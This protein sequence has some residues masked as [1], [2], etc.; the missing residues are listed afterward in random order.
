MRRCLPAAGVLFQD[1]SIQIGCR[2]ETEGA[3]GTVSVFFGNK[4]DGPF[5]VF[6]VRVQSTPALTA[7]Q[8]D[9][10]PDVVE[11]RKQV[12]VSFKIACVMVR[13]GCCARLGARESLVAHARADVRVDCTAIQGPAG[14]AG[15]VF[16]LP[17]RGLCTAVAPAGHGAALHHRRLSAV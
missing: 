12:K 15:V 6:K 1:D 5:R 10:A 9:V 16:D 2:I 17:H 13:G 8:V 7:E 11:A 4:T 14:I 3:E